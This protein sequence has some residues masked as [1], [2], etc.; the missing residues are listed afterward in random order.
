MKIFA[1]VFPTAACLAV[2]FTWALSAQEF[3]ATITGTNTDPSG[4]RVPQV[5]VQAINNATQ[6]SYKTKT[7]ETG[8]YLIPYVLPGTYTVRA[9]AQGFKT[10]VQENVL[11][12]GGVT[13]GLNLR[14]QLGTDDRNGRS[15]SSASAARDEPAGPAMPS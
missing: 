8:V 2:V 7:T 14:L 12:Q 1:R 10:E 5:D 11:V 3:R 4:S 9:K 6:Q 13:V 15:N